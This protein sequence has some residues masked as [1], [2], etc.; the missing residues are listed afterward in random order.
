[1]ASCPS[2]LDKL[3]MKLCKSGVLPYTEDASMNDVMEFICCRFN[4]C[5]FPS[6]TDCVLPAKQDGEERKKGTQLLFSENK[7]LWTLCS[8]K[9]FF[10]KQTS[11]NVFLIVQFTVESWHDGFYVVNVVD[12]VKIN[13]C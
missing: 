10:E 5:L 3:R 13:E 7:S 9:T 8:R 6:I 2:G 11:E 1:M 4:P 12:V